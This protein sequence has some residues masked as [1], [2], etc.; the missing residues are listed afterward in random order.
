MVIL[1]HFKTITYIEQEA[2]QTALGNTTKPVSALYLDGLSQ[3]ICVPGARL[4]L[5]RL[6]ITDGF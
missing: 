2:T 1:E 4:E 5:A 3:V 6:Y